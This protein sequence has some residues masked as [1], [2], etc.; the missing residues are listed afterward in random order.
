MAKEFYG[1]NL[2]LIR[3]FRDLTLN[4]IAS[5]AGVTRQFVHR[6]ET[7]LATPSDEQISLLSSVLNVEE[8]FFRTLD[9]KRVEEH[10]FHFRKLRTTKVRTKEHIVALGEVFRRLATLIDNHLDLPDPDF[11][12]LECSTEADIERAAEHCRNHWGL[13]L[14]PIENVTRVAENAGALVTDFAGLS[15]EVDALSIC[16]SR[17]IIVRNSAKSSP[18]RLRF[19]LSHEIGHFVMH[20]GRVTGDKLSESEANRFA[21]AFLLPRSTFLNEFPVMN[22]IS[23]KRISEIKQTF[24]VSK[25]AILYRARQLGRLTEQQYTGAVIRLRKHEGKFEKDDY[26]IDPVEQPE[27]IHNALAVLKDHLNISIS[28]MEIELGLGKNSLSIILGDRYSSSILDFSQY[29]N[30]VPF[31]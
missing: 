28:D 16:A 9:P 3:L 27:M 25:A 26:L 8:S 20:E 7:S 18:G 11:P 13:G 23:W 19:D 1:N 6:W 30:V 5:E 2:R 12:S 4:D 14:G 17:P 10:Q 31:R 15:T 22:R 24:K 21:S 29:K